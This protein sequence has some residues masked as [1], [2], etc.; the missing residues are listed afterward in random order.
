M[1]VMLD[2]GGLHEGQQP[3]HPVFVLWQQ[4][5]VVP[6]KQKGFSRQSREDGKKAART[7]QCFLGCSWSLAMP[8]AGSRLAH[9]EHVRG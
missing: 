4:L 6:E 8:G 5:R 9:W 3:G 7:V 2:H 1:A